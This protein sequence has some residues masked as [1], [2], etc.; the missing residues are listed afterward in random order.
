MP[1]NGKL[2]TVKFYNPTAGYGFVVAVREFS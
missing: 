2:G 1:A